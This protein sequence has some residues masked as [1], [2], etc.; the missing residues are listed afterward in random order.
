MYCTKQEIRDSVFVSLFSCPGNVLELYRVLHPEDTTVTLSDIRILGVG[1]ILLSSL[2]NNLEF[3]VRDEKIILVETQEEASPNIAFR[4]FG[5]GAQTLLN[6]L[7]EQGYDIEKETE[8]PI[9]VP[10]LENYAIQIS[11]D[12]PDVWRLSDLIRNLSEEYV[13][14]VIKE[15]KENNIINQYIRFYRIANEQMSRY[16]HS[17][18][19]LKE[20]IDICLREGVLRGFIEPRKAEIINMMNGLFGQAEFM[21]QNERANRKEGQKQGREDE[22]LRV[23]R[24]MME[25]L[26]LTVDQALAAASVPESER[27]MFRGLLAEKDRG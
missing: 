11:N 4:M 16:G 23:V 1:R 17:Q 27:E 26:N 20:I 2:F 7:T 25:N 8:E 9:P 3:S 18:E 13:V 14:R 12:S 19:T 6:Y 22:L 10:R 24:A 15:T 5:R 21:R